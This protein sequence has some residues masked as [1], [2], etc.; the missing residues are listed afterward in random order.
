MEKQ[1]NR[2]REGVREVEDYGKKIDHE[3]Y[4]LDKDW[5][6]ARRKYADG[7]IHFR[8]KEISS[9]DELMPIEHL[10]LDMPPQ[11]ISC[12]WVFTLARDDWREIT[13]QNASLSVK[14]LIK[15]RKLGVKVH[16]PRRPKNL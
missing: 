2:K 13:L 10:F 12:I 7:K 14:F 1:N 5:E 8:G 3:V 9:M 4:L 6:E 11:V 15:L 16:I